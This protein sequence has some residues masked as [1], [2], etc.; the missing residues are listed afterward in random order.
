MSHPNN[1]FSKYFLNVHVPDSVLGAGD[2]TV[3]RIDEIN[4]LDGTYKFL[5]I[6]MQDIIRNIFF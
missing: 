6:P 5:M 2:K 3:N 1:L 4:C